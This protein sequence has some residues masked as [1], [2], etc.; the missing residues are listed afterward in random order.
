MPTRLDLK[1]LL[2]EL[3][4]LKKRQAVLEREIKEEAERVQRETR[5]LVAMCGTLLGQP[6]S[7]RGRLTLGHE[8]TRVQK[9]IG[10]GQTI[11]SDKT[12][13]LEEQCGAPRYKGYGHCEKHQ[14]AYWALAKNRKAG[15][16]PRTTVA[17]HAQAREWA[18]AHPEDP[19]AKKILALQVQ[20]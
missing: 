16:M 10:N 5:D 20:D 9:S 19:R 7:G 17:T 4:A 8:P 14:K 11:A 6:V 12:I 13:C 3:A 2:A 15:A 1:K 18:E